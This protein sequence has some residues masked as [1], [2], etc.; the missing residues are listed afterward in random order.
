KPIPV[1]YITQHSE[2]N[3]KLAA[4]RAGCNG[5]F[6]KPVDVRLMVDYLDKLLSADDE[7]EN[8]FR[9]LIVEDMLSIAQVNANILQEV[10]MKTHIVTEP[11]LALQELQDFNPELILMDMYM[12]LCSGSEL[13]QVIRLHP[14][15]VSI[16]IVYLSVE[17]DLLKQLGA[18]SQGGDDFLT[19]PIDPNHLISSVSIRAKRYRDI[20]SHIIRDGLTGLLNHSRIKEEL[21][22]ELTRS[23]R[24]GKPL[25]F[26]MI[27]L[28]HFKSVNDTYGHPVGD[29]VLKSLSRLLKDRLRKTD[30]VGRYG[31]EEFAVILP[32]A[33]REQAIMLMDNIREVFSQDVH[34]ADDGRG[35]FVTF[36]CGIVCYQSGG[37]HINIVKLADDALYQAKH[38]GRN[39]IV[40]SN[41]FK[42]DS[43]E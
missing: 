33:G 42:T 37:E 12:P 41:T 11:A 6:T 28:D 18:M 31:G 25:A 38:E 5:Y 34:L 43:N 14:E 4:V 20:R 19:K 23:A 2:F 1:I 21:D 27:D 40:A 7:S 17:R 10:G 15:F 39:R 16:P 26:A 24:E 35:F 29:R 36:S 8:P 22:A 3:S 30:R 13:A 9:I 32:N